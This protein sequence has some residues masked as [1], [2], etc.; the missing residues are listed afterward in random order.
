MHIIFHCNS[1]FWHFVLSFNVVIKIDLRAIIKAWLNSSTHNPSPQ[2]EGW[3]DDYF[4]KAKDWVLKCAK[5]VVETTLIGLVFN[6]LSHLVGVTSKVEFACALVWG[7]GG[8]LPSETRANF[9]KE[10]VHY[11]Y[12]LC[13]WI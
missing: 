8:N 11:E 2:L 4:Y 9:A 10:V 12:T 1:H 5:R 13:G 3:I 7:L 6:G